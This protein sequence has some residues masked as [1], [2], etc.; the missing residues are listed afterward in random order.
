[1]TIHRMGLTAALTLLVSALLTSAQF[2]ESTPQDKAAM[3]LYFTSINFSTKRDFKRALLNINKAISMRP[4]R[5]DFLL[6]RSN[7]HQKLCR[8]DLALADAKFA[9]VSEPE[10]WLA[11]IRASE[12]LLLMNRPKDALAALDAIPASRATNDPMILTYRGIA[13]ARLNQ[14]DKSV[15]SLQAAVDAFKKL[16][17]CPNICVQAKNE[18]AK[19]A[20]SR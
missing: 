14:R 19:Q 8:L 2:A 12:L 15:E 18:L 1:M 11:R 20:V 16:G 9:I 3:Q 13:L 6:Q 4:Q 5:A 10:N 7:I 17:V